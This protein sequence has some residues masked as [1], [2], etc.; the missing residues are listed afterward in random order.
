MQLIVKTVKI[1]IKNYSTRTC[2]QQLRDL[3]LGIVN[4]KIPQHVK[5]LHICLWI[6]T[7]KEVN[8]YTLQAQ[9]VPI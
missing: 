8:I 2:N 1:K 9:E 7:G 6:C 4:L 3:C 5:V